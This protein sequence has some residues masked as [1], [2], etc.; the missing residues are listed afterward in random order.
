MA[1]RYLGFDH[2]EFARL[3]RRVRQ[4]VCPNLQHGGSLVVNKVWRYV[5]E[6]RP[7]TFLD[8]VLQLQTERR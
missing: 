6:V 2:I 4:E 7:H 1:T 8:V 5:A 3:L